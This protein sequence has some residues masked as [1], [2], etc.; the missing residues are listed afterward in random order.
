V[1]P[2]GALTVSGVT[3]DGMSAHNAGVGVGSAGSLAVS[4]AIIQ[5]FYTQ[6]D[7]GGIA[8]NGGVVAVTGSKF[9]S[10]LASAGG[11]IS[12][13]GGTLVVGLSTFDNC[14]AIISDGG[15]IL[16]WAGPTGGGGGLIVTACTFSNDV[17]ST[18]GG[19]IALDDGGQASVVDSTFCSD[20][21]S[22][23]GAVSLNI[24]RY[25]SDYAVGLGITSSTVAG[26]TAKDGGGV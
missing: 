6:G 9:L 22:Y 26:N 10:D 2:G 11:G 24:S 18:F 21:A 5:H 12:N 16:D 19:G 13:V 15:G 8:D 23:G 7:G 3:L 20:N 14:C 4:D 25:N 1:A 17:A